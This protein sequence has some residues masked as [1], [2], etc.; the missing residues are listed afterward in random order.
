MS[1]QS[2]RQGELFQAE[3]WQAAYQ[4]FTNISFSSYSYNTIKAALLNYISIQ[5][6]EDFTDWSENSEFLF[7]IDLLSYLGE[8]LAYRVELNARD[9]ILDTAERKQ[10]IINFT[11]SLNYTMHRNIAASGLVKILSVSTTQSVIDS[12]GTDLAN[13]II[14]WNDASNA[15]WYEQ[16]ILVLNSSFIS[17]NQFG[18][19]VQSITS[20]NIITQLYEFNNISGLSAADAFSVPV[21]GQAMDFEIIN[22]SI[23]TTTNSLYEVNPDQNTAKHV[24]YMND[25]SG[26]DSIHTGFFL[27]FKQG[28]LRFEDYLFDLPIENR[29]IELAA[30]NVNDSDVWVQ[31]VDDNGNSTA[32]WVKVD[33]FEN[34]V[35]N[36][37][38]PEV[39]NIFSV[40]TRDNDA[41]TVNFSDGRL[42]TIPLGGFRFWYRQSNGLNYTIRPADMRG[43]VISVPYTANTTSASDQS[44]SL[45]LNFSLQESVSNSAATETINS[46][47]KNASL[48]YYT[49]DR[50]ANNQDYNSFPLS[51]GQ[52]I[53]K[54]KAINRTYSGHSQYIDITDPTKNYSST[55]EFGDDGVLYQEP[56]EYQVVETLPTSKTAAVIV[57]N[58]IV[59]LIANN[60]YEM[61]FYAYMP[62]FTLTGLYWTQ[63]NASTSTSTGFFVN[64][65]GSP[66]PVGPTVSSN[67]K[68]IGDNALIQFVNP[69]D[70]TDYL[71][72][73]VA[74]LDG[75]G[76]AMTITGNGPVALSGIVPTGWIANVTYAQFRSTFLS[77][78]ITNIASEIIDNNSFGIRYDLPTASW[79]IISAS[80]LNSTGDFS[81]T[82]A[83]D[84]SNTNLDASWVILAEYS[85]TGWTFTARYLQYV[86]ESIATSR[87]FFS[88]DT[89]AVNIS[90]NTVNY[91]TITVLKFNTAPG[92]SSPIDNDYPFQVSEAIRYADGFA[93]PMRIKVIA[94]RSSVTGAILNPLEFNIVVDPDA[95]DPTR[96][97]FQKEYIDAGGFS[98]YQT[99]ET[100]TVEEFLTIPALLAETS[101]VNGDI[102]FVLS[103]QQF[104]EY[105]DGASTSI[106]ASLSASTLT[107]PNHGLNTGSNIILFVNPPPSGTISLP[108][109][110]AANTLYYVFVIDE[111]T[112]AIGNSYADVMLPNPILVTFT[113]AGIGTISVLKEITQTENY[114]AF[115]GRKDINYSYEHFS[116]Q[117]ERIDPSITNIM[118]MY[119]LTRDYYND[120]ISWKNS[121]S[122]D[123][124]PAPPT[125]YELGNQFS[126]LQEYKMASDEM[127]FQSAKFK[128]LFGNGANPEVKAT[129]VVVPGTDTTITNNEIAQQVIATVDDFFDISQN[130]FDFGETVYFSEVAAYIHKKL[131]Q[132]T[133]VISSVV[134]VPQYGTSRFGDLY[135]IR[136][137]SDELPLSTATVANVQ[138]VDNLTDSILRIS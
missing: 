131:A 55:I 114:K 38:S 106:T 32:D 72:L 95:S 14:I 102:S 104:F 24:I 69:A 89:K 115:L 1:Q 4:A 11:K 23:N 105:V 39:R 17:T 98:Y 84:T 21:S 128:V 53:I 51:L 118:D 26:N 117:D 87:F 81:L 92:S 59:P 42:G 60:D 47:K 33:A 57:Q 99:L 66:V 103:T 70:S 73:S 129:F 75:N 2:I 40:T 34:I 77:S 96:Y 97:I 119:V 86:F 68:Y 36:S 78:E 135:Q 76:T 110:L 120:V 116:D 138:I 91:D 9:N 48:V 16:F 30:T 12:N 124:I 133:K 8:T 101:W 108:S 100:N 94:Q 132:E 7:I 20:D 71:W 56:Y 27:M 10:S 136:C 54:I 13:R 58:D 83:G 109:P 130:R 18:N 45:L 22:P 90:N 35:S 29:E 79:E 67:A 46:A 93:D 6:P 43:L 52:T 5:H 80:N 107:I 122:D 112:V 19:P 44:Y 88:S 125:S 28:T 113:T 65:S 74:D 49:Q 15:D 64:V 37:L 41:I 121:Q 134:I 31:Q 25:G 126:I 123:A 127:I 82:Y 111:N 85:I 3:S 137:E 61:F 62:S 63:V 50:M